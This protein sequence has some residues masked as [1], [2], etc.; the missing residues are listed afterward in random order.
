MFRCFLV[1]SRARLRAE[2]GTVGVASAMRAGSGSPTGKDLFD[3]PLE[4]DFGSLFRMSH[5]R[6]G[7]SRAAE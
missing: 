5:S 2:A 4:W 3:Q 7:L 1:F 6:C